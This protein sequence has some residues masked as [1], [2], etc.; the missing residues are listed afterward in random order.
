MSDPGADRGRAGRCR[1]APRSPGRR[2]R[3]PG[4]DDP[5]DHPRGDPAHPQ[6]RPG[7]RP[8]RASPDRRPAALP[9]PL[10]ARLG[11]VVR[12]LA[13]PVGPRSDRLRAGRRGPRHRDVRDV[14]APVRAPALLQLDRRPVPPL[15]PGLPAHRAGEGRRLRLA[16]GAAPAPRVP[17]RPARPATGDVRGGPGRAAQGLGQALAS[18]TTW[19]ASSPSR[20]C[21]ARWRPASRLPVREIDI[22]DDDLAGACD[23]IADWLE[24]TGGLWAPP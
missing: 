3:A 12:L 5:E 21:S 1:R 9:L 20:S 23:R 17:R 16:G 24:S 22:S 8:E 7:V 18:T 11:R 14:G 4:E 10:A 15:D 2:P 6:D 13:V 19:R